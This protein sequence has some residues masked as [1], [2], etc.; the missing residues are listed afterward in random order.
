ML[1]PAAI[2]RPHAL[3]YTIAALIIIIS[4]IASSAY[5]YVRIDQTGRA[6]IMDRAETISQAVTPE[7]LSAL[8]GTEED[9]ERSEYLTL[10]SLLARMRAVN[11][12]IR[13]VYLVGERSDKSLFFYVDSEDAESP[14]YSPPGQEYP[15]ASAAMYDL[16]TTGT[17]RTEGPTR[18]R[19]GVWISGYAP[20]YDV[21]GHVRAL[22]GLDMPASAFVTNAVAYALL[23]FLFSMVL[24]VILVGTA[25]LRARDY[26]ALGQKA[27]FL[28]IASHEIRTPLTGIRWAVEGVLA[29]RGVLTDPHTRDILGRVHESC[30]TLI[31]RVNNLLDVTAFESRGKAV[32]HKSSIDIRS[33]V[34]EIADSLSLSAAQRNVSIVIDPT[35]DT[36]TTMMADP[37]TMHHVFFNLISNAVKYTNPDTEVRLSY[38]LGPTMH[39]FIFSDKGPGMSP[40][41][42]QH[43]F[44]G[45]H[46]TLEAVR[47]GQYGS[48]LGLYLVRTAATLHGGSVTVESAPGTGARFTLN[49]PR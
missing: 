28:S 45:Y 26:R 21:D 30:L 14:D 48:G 31:A 39:S 1:V 35:Y 29:T 6:H 5:V 17:P 34:S 44:E 49:L 22:L 47:S 41:D 23:P 40:E 13:F 18:D 12:D 3:G 38:Q 24:L 46:R 25:Q 37:Q 19:W 15:E 43:I 27:E 9:V 8:A 42:Q 32:L 36:A 2:K 10:K 20:I 16:F 7:L 4:G 11:S 33:F